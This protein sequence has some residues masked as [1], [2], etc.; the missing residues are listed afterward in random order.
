MQSEGFCF[1]A[2]IVRGAYMHEVSRVPCNM[3]L[4]FAKTSRK[5]TNKNKR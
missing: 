1:G 2:K 3:H 4:R 5:K